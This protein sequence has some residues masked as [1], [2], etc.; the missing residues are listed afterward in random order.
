M[1]INTRPHFQAENI[2]I[3]T[4]SKRNH[5][6][7]VLFSK[8][9]LAIDLIG[10][11]VNKAADLSRHPGS[12]KQDV[13]SIDVVHSEGKGVPEGVVNVCLEIYHVS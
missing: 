11:N 12:L 6:L 9:S 7:T 5:N 13:S 1:G 3:Y 4:V 2:L 8:T 10:A